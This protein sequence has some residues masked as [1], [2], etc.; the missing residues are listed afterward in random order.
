ML[1]VE[2]E[3]SGEHVVWIDEKSFMRIYATPNFE[4]DGVSINVDY[5]CYNIA[6]DGFHGKIRG[7]DHYKQIVKEMVENML[8]HL[9]ECKC[10]LGKE[11]G[12]CV[13]ISVEG[14]SF[15]ICT[16]C[17]GT[18]GKEEHGRTDILTKERVVEEV[19]RMIDRYFEEKSAELRLKNG[20]ISP[21]QSFELDNVIEKLV[22]VVIQ[23][24]A[25]NQEVLVEET[26]M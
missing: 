1:H 15:Y 21:G 17:S 20:D 23:W 11:V 9:P 26:K 16:R 7:Y 4:I 5:D 22:D 10:V 24:A 3:L 14:S 13:P 19:G 18:I 2:E 25:Q 12:V 8:A 6:T